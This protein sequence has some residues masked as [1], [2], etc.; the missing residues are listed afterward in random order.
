MRIEQDEAGGCCVIMGLIIVA[1]GVGCLWGAAAGWIAAGVA[2]LT[3]GILNAVH[4]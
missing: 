4:K 2:L 1:M 3:I